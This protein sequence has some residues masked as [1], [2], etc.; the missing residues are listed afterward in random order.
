MNDTVMVQIPVSR[1]AAAALQEQARREKVGKLVS[2][3]LRPEAPVS[4]PLAALIAEI[5]AAA[6]AEGLSDKE[7]DAELAAYNADRRL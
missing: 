1:E 7:I 3:L 6:R 4:D 5:K 2:N